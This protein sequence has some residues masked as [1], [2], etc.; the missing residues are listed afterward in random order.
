MTHYTD[1]M[2][3]NTPETRDRNGTVE[4]EQ[5]NPT[6]DRQT[7]R[8]ADKQTNGLGQAWQDVDENMR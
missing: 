4:V 2:I 3:H 6:T 7:G 5:Q 8:Q 1:Y